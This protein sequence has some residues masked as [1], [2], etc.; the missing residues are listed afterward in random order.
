MVGSGFLRLGSVVRVAARDSIPV[1]RVQHRKAPPTHIL[2]AESKFDDVRCARWASAARVPFDCPQLITKSPFAAEA[3]ERANN[4]EVQRHHRVAVHRRRLPGTCVCRSWE[5]PAQLPALL[6]NA[7]CQGGPRGGPAHLPRE[8]DHPAERA[9]ARGP[10]LRS[11]S[12]RPRRAH[13]LLGR[14][15]SVPRVQHRK[16]PPTH[17]ATAARVPFRCSLVTSLD[18][19]VTR[20]CRVN[21]CVPCWGRAIGRVCVDGIASRGGSRSPRVRPNGLGQDVTRWPARRARRATRLRPSARARPRRRRVRARRRR[22]RLAC[23]S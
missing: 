23:M 2:A 18:T 21:L 17:L 11:G 9:R 7:A 22:S 19:I 16:A 3:H 20:W 1:P 10:P 15:L 13:H 14:A 5:L 12:H 4:R 6:D 8:H